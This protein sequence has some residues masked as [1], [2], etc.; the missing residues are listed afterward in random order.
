MK[1]WIVAIEISDDGIRAE[2]TIE[3]YTPEMIKELLAD[4]ELDAGIEIV[5]VS[6]PILKAR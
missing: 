2:R 5:Q 6:D 3:Y 1:H 4:I